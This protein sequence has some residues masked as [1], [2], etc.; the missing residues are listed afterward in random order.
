L[1]HDHALRLQVVDDQIAGQTHARRGIAGRG[2]DFERGHT[3]VLQ[4]VVA[5]QIGD[6]L[7]RAVPAQ[8][9]RRRAQHQMGSRDLP[10]DQ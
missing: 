8:I 5:R 2:S 1:Q 3:R 9:G 4:I 10:R 7:R 6:G